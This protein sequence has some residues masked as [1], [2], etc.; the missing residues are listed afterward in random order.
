MSSPIFRPKIFT[1]L[2]GYSRA[3]LAADTTAGLTVGLVALPLALAFG[4]ASIPPEVAA[5]VGLSPPAMGLFTAVIAGFLISFLGGTRAAIG[6]PTG[7]FIVIVYAIAAEHGYAG[8]ALATLMAGAILILLG[9][10][11]LGGMIKYIPYPVTTGF[12]SGIAVIIL[13]GQLKDLLGLA[14]SSESDIVPP[15]FIGKIQWCA[16]HLHT[17]DATTAI[18]G[19]TCAAVIYL[20]PR[21]VTRRIPGPIVV[22]IVAT[23]V[24]QIFNLPVETIGSRFGEIPRGIPAPHLPEIDFSRAPELIG[25]ALTIALLAG[26]ESLLC[27]VVADGMLGTRH[28]SNT[29]LIAQGAANIVCPLFAGIPATGA[30]ARTAANVESGGRTPISGMVHAVTLLIIMV[31]LG[32]YAGLIPLCALASVLM[33]VAWRMSEFHRF[34]WLL[35]GPRSDAAVL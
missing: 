2:K 6:G 10:A 35:S 27:A 7:A 5:E 24:C 33:V 15:D 16:A 25:P 34:R 14:P 21:F 1:C 11:R 29:E 17:I 31:A 3:Q 32:R 26:I 20:W 12:T 18:L 8:L 22:L 13:T 28:R 9:L 4:I 23:A 30:I 19:L